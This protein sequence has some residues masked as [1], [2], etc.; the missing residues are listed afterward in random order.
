MTAGAGGDELQGTCIAPTPANIAA[1]HVAREMQRVYPARRMSSSLRSWPQNATHLA[2]MAITPGQARHALTWLRSRAPG[3]LLERASPWLTFDAIET[4]RARMHDGLR[5]FEYGSG[6]STLFWLRWRVELCSVEHDP[7]WYHEIRSRL[8]GDRA[9]DYRLVEPEPFAER[10]VGL[11]P[12]DPEAYG[13]G[14]ESFRGRTFRRYASQIDEFPDGHFDIVLVDGRAR[15]ACLRHAVPKVRPGGVLI[16][17]NADRAYYVARLG[18]SLRTF[19]QQRWPGA[20]PI[21][22]VM[23]RTDFFVRA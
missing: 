2:R 8:P 19:T 20:A 18:D 9:V 4:L 22:P 5:V 10:H 14:D 13:S 16:L 12:A 17:D 23:T 7:S 3:Y 6:G 21:V 11:D 15:P 1:G